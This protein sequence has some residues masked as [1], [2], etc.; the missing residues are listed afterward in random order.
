MNKKMENG[1]CK[2]E[3]EKKTQEGWHSQTR[4]RVTQV[5]DD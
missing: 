5:F 4:L 1:R 2:K 3:D